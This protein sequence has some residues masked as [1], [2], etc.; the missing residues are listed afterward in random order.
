MHTTPTLISRL[1]NIRPNERRP[2][3][4]AFLAAFLMFTGYMMLRPVRETMGVTAGVRALP[5]LFWATFVVTLLMQPLYGWALSQ[6]SRRLVLPGIYLVIAFT[7]LAFHAWFH[8]EADHTWIAR[9]WFVWVSV[10]NLFITAALWSTMVDAFSREEASRLF[11]FVAGGLSLGGLAGPA[12]AALLAK[13]IGTVN[14]LLIAS[15][16][17]VAAAIV[18]W[19]LI[20]SSRHIARDDSASESTMAAESDM[21]RV[22]TWD[23]FRQLLKSRYL[24]GIALFVMLLTFVTTVLYVE[25]QRIVGASIAGRDAQTT[26][27]ATVDFWV[28]A[29]ALTLQFL[30]FPHLLRWFGF[31]NMLI[32]IP[33]LMALVFAGLAMAPSLVV[34]TAAM[35][36]RRIGEYGITRPCR[37]ILFIVVSPGE[38]YLAKNLIDTFVYRGGD[39]ISASLHA[40]VVALA[41]GTAVAASAAGIFGIAIALAWMI[42]ALWLAAAYARRGEK[43][44]IPNPA[45]G[46]AFEGKM[47]ENARQ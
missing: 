1:T 25:Q 19:L 39:A 43:A 26:Y 44:L 34:I 42:L 20:R 23:A 6:F 17:F 38:K 12:L 37:E 28:Q 47:P 5:A 40:G 7:M 45:N 33:L 32:A 46:A 11:G 30:L 2:L 16:F 9:A 31:R 15:A 13:P 14:L 29:G 36:I 41:A 24:L 3:L 22:S 8:L 18:M 35:M 10:F 4:L 27:F 21:L